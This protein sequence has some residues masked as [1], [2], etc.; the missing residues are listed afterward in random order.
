MRTVRTSVFSRGPLLAASIF[1]CMSVGACVDTY[2]EPDFTRSQPPAHP[3]GASAAGQ[4]PSSDRRDMGSADQGAADLGADGA[5]TSDAALDAHLPPD[6]WLRPAEPA[7]LTCPE[8]GQRAATCAWIT[9]CLASQSCTTARDQTAAAQVQSACT[10]RFAPDLI[11]TLCA[12]G[13]SCL[14]FARLYPFCDFLD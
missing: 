6:A 12:E 5:N 14:E 8:T 9:R 3:R 11:A 10:T 2:E 1:S 13:L 7:A 4:T